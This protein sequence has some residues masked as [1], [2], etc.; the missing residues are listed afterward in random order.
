MH[1]LTDNTEERHLILIEQQPLMNVKYSLGYNQVVQKSICV[2][3]NYYPHWSPF[4]AAF[5]NLPSTFETNN[6]IYN[7]VLINDA[8]KILFSLKKRSG[9]YLFIDYPLLG[10]IVLNQFNKNMILDL[11]LDFDGSYYR[12]VDNALVTPFPIVIPLYF[13]LKL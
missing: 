12:C 11:D 13:K 9:S 4:F 8:S 3:V 2:D 7:T 6:N 1:R 5:N 10:F